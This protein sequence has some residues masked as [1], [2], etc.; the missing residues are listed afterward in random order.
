[1]E[2]ARWIVDSGASEDTAWLRPRVS[3]PVAQLT[4]SVVGFTGSGGP[5]GAG[6][7]AWN[8]MSATPVSATPSVRVAPP[9]SRE[10]V[11]ADPASTA[12]LSAAWPAA[13]WASANGWVGSPATKRGSL[14]TTPPPI[15]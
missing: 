7:S 1:M 5:P 4:H 6:A 11:P 9:I 14:H 3:L 8:P 12:G 15:A 13:T 2:S 10:I